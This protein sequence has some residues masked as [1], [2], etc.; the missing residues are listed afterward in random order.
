MALYA[1]LRVANLKWWYTPIIP[2]LKRLRQKDHEFQPSLG[3]RNKILSQ[4]TSK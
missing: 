1:F 2:A 4:K 3:Y